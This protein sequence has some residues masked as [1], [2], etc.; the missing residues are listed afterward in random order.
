WLQVELAA[1]EALGEAGLVPAEAAEAI[2]TRAKVDVTRILELEARVKHDVIA[3]TMN[4][5]ESIGD[6]AAARWLHYGLTSNDVVDTAQALMVREASIIIERD[7][8][9]F[10]E[11]LDLRAHEFRHTAQIGRTHGVHAE[12]ITF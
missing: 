2:R 7:L 4:V 3:F 6:P 1:T 9:L 12:P 10:G 11:V 5:G 8:I